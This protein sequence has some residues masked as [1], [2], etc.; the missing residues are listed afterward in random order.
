[1]RKQQTAGASFGAAKPDLKPE[2]LKLP[3]GFEKFLR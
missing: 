1:V 2:D 3:K